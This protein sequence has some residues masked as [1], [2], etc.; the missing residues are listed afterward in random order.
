MKNKI[1]KA[2]SI[3]A[4]VLLGVSLAACGKKTEANNNLSDIVYVATHEDMGFLGE[5]EYL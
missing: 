3:A 4:I 1:I 5:N 2:L